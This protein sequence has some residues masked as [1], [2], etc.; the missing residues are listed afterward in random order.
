MVGLIKVTDADQD[1]LETMDVLV[2]MGLDPKSE[3]SLKKYNLLDDCIRVIF[4]LR[5]FGSFFI[6]YFLNIV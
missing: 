4:E 2:E 3:C 1:V 6:L 5:L